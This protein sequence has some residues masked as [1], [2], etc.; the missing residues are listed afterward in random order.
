MFVTKEM[1]LADWPIFQDKFAEMQI[2]HGAPP[3]FALFYRNHNG[4]RFSTIAASGLH[5][6]RANALSPGGW[7][8]VEHLDGPGWALLVGNG[9]VHTRLGVH[10]GIA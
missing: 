9:D 6:S 5:L 8:E 10:L 1:K 4:V 3:D 2:V 7:S